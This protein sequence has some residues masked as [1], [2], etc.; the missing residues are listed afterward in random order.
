MAKAKAQAGGIVES[1]RAFEAELDKNLALAKTNPEALPG[2]AKTV[3]N[4]ITLGPRV[5]EASDWAATQ[6][7]NAAAAGGRWLAR[8]T[9]PRKNPVEAATAAKVKWRNKIQEAI[10]NDSFARGL[11]NVDVDE[12]YATI[13]AGGETPF[14]SGVQRRQAKVQRVVGELRDQVVAL[15]VAIDKMPVDTDAQRAARLLAARQG[16]ITIGRKRKGLT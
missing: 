10:T 1:L 8:V 9:R 3:G 6:V 4:P 15:A 13:T 5:I 7:A 14:T 2:R 11:A 16:M 12:M